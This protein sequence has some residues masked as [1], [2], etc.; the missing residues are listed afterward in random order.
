M[1]RCRAQQ[2][3]GAE[4]PG[5]AQRSTAQPIQGPVTAICLHATLISPP[6]AN[7]AGMWRHG[8]LTLSPYVSAGRLSYASTRG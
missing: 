3:R 5:S 7:R 6:H 4:E 1:D 8:R 2:Q